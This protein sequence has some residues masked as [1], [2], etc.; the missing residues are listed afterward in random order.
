[1]PLR[2]PITRV[3][4]NGHPWSGRR[5][6]RVFCG[7]RYWPVVGVCGRRAVVV[8]DVGGVVLWS[9]WRG[10]E[11]TDSPKCSRP[12]GRLPVEGSGGG[13]SGRYDGGR[14]SGVY[15]VL[16]PANRRRSRKRR[17]NMRRRWRNGTHGWRA[18]RCSS[19]PWWLRLRRPR[20]PPTQAIGQR[21]TVLGRRRLSAGRATSSGWGPTADDDGETCR[22]HVLNHF[23]LYYLYSW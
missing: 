6:G 10:R 9:V 14:V 1:M 17:A 2:G 20:R 13:G 5:L 18:D 8:P 12:H 15:R 16:W 19:G 11:A 21:R 4:W 3:F 7:Q 23:E 22:Q